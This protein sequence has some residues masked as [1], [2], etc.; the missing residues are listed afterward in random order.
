[1]CF[2]RGGGAS[3][4]GVSR[5]AYAFGHWLCASAVGSHLALCRTHRPCA[6]LLRADEGLFGRRA[7]PLDLRDRRRGAQLHPYPY[8]RTGGAAQVLD[9]E[10]QH[11]SHRHVPRHGR[12]VRRRDLAPRPSRTAPGART[13]HSDQDPDAERRPRDP[14]VHRRLRCRNRYQIH[15]DG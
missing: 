5:A 15:V 2:R 1:M 10:G 12:S 14:L 7:V 6:R 3:A 11:R 4:H 13:G 9:R 8:A